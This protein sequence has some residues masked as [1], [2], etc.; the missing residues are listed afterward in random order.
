[1][2]LK[3]KYNY[4]MTLNE[5]LGHLFLSRIYLDKKNDKFILSNKR[6]QIFAFLKNY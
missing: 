1:M 5:V 4:Q 2:K 3:H 6:N